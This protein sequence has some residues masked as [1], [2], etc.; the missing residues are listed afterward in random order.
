MPYG[1]FEEKQRFNQIWLWTIL[2][3]ISTIILYQVSFSLIRQNEDTPL[4]TTSILTV[5]GPILFVIGLLALF[6]YARLS[7]RISNNDIQITFRPFF[8]KPK[9]I[10]W[11]DIEAV[12]VRKYNALLEY[13]G[14]G[15]RFGWKGRAYNTSGNMGMQILMKSGK[16]ILIGT[17]K[18]KELDAFLKKYILSENQENTY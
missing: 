4:S 15:I 3:G 10:K 8:G 16:K 11:I 17:H 1:T 13:G 9:V 18:P 6:F 7:T 12:K 14:W 5:L 2:I